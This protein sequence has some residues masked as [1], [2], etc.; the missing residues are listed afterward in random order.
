MT[1]PPPGSPDH[2]AVESAELFTYGALALPEVMQVLL[3]RVP[4][5]TAASAAGWRV[6]AA[7]VPAKAVMIRA[8][9]VAHGHVFSD[10]SN[11]EW[12]LLDAFQVGCELRLLGLTNGR[13]AW[14]YVYADQRQASDEDW[15][16]AQFENNSFVAYLKSCAEWRKQYQARLDRR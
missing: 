11:A 1:L 10:L 13:T 6:A 9:A 2:F 16:A 15:D 5:S 3:G 4:V 14:S 7:S 8:E 12:H